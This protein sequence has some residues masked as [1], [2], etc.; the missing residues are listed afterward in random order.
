KQEGKDSGKAPVNMDDFTYP[1]DPPR[2]RESAVVMLAD[3][4]EAAI[5]TLQ[6][7]TAVK[8]EKFIQELIVKKVEHG[9]LA[10]SE[11]SFRDLEIIKKAFVRVLAGYYHS[12]IEYPK[13]DEPESSGAVQK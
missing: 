6:K 5:R 7:P 13:I 11:L 8:M 4:T 10:Q 3:V 9:Q 2:S 12:R 1:G